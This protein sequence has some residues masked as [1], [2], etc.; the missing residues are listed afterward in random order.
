MKK[1]KGD[2]MGDVRGRIGNWKYYNLKKYN[3]GINLASDHS[4]WLPA[5]HCKLTLVDISIMMSSTGG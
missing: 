1:S 4:F 5:W 2:Y 3:K